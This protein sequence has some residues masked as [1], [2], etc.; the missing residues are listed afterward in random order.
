MLYNRNRRGRNTGGSPGGGRNG[1]DQLSRFIL[2][3]V[4]G[5]S[6]VGGIFRI[7]SL[8]ILAI[9]LIIIAYYRAFSRNVSKRYAENQAYLQWVTNLKGAFNRFKLRRV[10]KKTHKIYKCPNCSQKI[11]VPRGKG[12]IKIKCPNCRI[13]FIKNTGKL[14]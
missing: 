1:M 7:W 8:L 12:T 4:V 9:I 13:E 14:T 5:V 6:I 2:F 11:R 10:D 3:I